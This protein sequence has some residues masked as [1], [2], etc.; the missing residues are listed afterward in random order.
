MDIIIYSTFAM[1]SAPIIIQTAIFFALS[2]VANARVASLIDYLLHEQFHID[3]GR[4]ILY[5]DDIPVNCRI[6]HP[7]DR[8]DRSA[9]KKDRKIIFPSPIDASR[10]D[11]N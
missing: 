7:I 6:V 3:N 1:H 9:V 4:K 10:V 5:T 8:N 11:I 2:D